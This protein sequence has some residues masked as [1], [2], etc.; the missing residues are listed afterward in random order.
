MKYVRPDQRPKTSTFEHLEN[1]VEFSK[2]DILL[3]Q[4]L[5]ALKIKGKK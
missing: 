4:H 1:K 5:K 2:I 3:I